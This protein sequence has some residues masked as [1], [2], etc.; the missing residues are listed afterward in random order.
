MV[1]LMYETEAGPQFRL[2]PVPH[3]TYLPGVMR[4]GDLIRVFDPHSPREDR[5]R[6]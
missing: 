6:P 3:P 2:Q 1:M 4:D 5:Y